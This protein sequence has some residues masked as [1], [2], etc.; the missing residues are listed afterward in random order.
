MECDREQQIEA[1]VRYLAAERAELVRRVGRSVP[2]AEAEDILQR[3]SFVTY[4]YIERGKCIGNI[5]G[6]FTVALHRII[7]DHYRSRARHPISQ[8]P[9]DETLSTD[10]HVYDDGT[11]RFRELLEQLLRSLEAQS[12]EGLAEVVWDLSEVGHTHDHEI[13]DCLSECGATQEQHVAFL[14]TR[15]PFN[16]DLILGI[17]ESSNDDH[18]RRRLEAAVE[19]ARAD[20]DPTKVGRGLRWRFDEALAAATLRIL[21]PTARASAASIRT[22]TIGGR[23]GLTELLRTRCAGCAR[24]YF[25]EGTFT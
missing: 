2:A 15:F 16:D 12:P 21:N 4:R 14:L 19:Q 24:K 18:L 1:L 11:H 23:R 10:V 6:F 3:A 5:G 9:S 8:L 13:I 20:C 22:H 25:R 7:V 17:V